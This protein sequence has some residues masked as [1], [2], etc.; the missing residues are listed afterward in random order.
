[1]SSNPSAAPVG[2]GRIDRRSL[3]RLLLRGTEAPD[4]HVDDMEHIAD[5]AAAS[6]DEPM[7]LAHQVQDSPGFQ[8]WWQTPRES[9][10]VLVEARFS[11]ADVLAAQ[12]GRAVTPYSVLCASV[13]SDLVCAH[14][15]PPHEPV[16][17]NGGGGGGGGGTAFV[18]TAAVVF[19][20]CNLHADSRGSFAGARGMLRSLV[21][22]LLVQFLPWGPDRASE[23]DLDF[24][25]GRGVLLGDFAA[26]DDEHDVS[27]Y[28]IRNLLD[29]LT[30]LVSQIAPD[31]TLYIIVDEASLYERT[32]SGW[33]DKFQRIINALYGTLKSVMIHITLS[34][35]NRVRALPRDRNDSLFA[36]RRTLGRYPG[37]PTMPPRCGVWATILGNV[38]D[39][40]PGSVMRRGSGRIESPS[41]SPRVVGRVGSYR[42]AT[43][44]GGVTPHTGPVSAT[45][46]AAPRSSSPRPPYPD[47]LA[48]SPPH[49]PHHR[50]LF[51]SSLA[52]ISMSPPR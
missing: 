34:G 12:G 44:H 52:G 50:R 46:V 41:L 49:Q 21:G 43:P 37:P 5:A 32:E 45:F 9:G 6:G 14:C 33:E 51:F 1:M 28:Q 40:V 11:P 29:L 18:A 15:I 10:A 4:T 2:D 35:S 24:G 42:S 19:F 3:H 47:D 27:G 26:P 22:Q 7:A 16:G 25:G 30:Q 8:R 36:P 39:M 17:G 23:P 38:R 48:L 20:A 31:I 13:A